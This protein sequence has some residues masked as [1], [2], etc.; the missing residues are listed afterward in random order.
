LIKRRRFW[1]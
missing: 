1:I